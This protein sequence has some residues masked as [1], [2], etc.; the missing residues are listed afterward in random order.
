MKSAVPEIRITPANKK[1]VNNEGGFVLYRMTAFRRVN[2]NYRL[3]WS[4]EWAA[5]PQTALEIMIELNNRYALDGS[6]P[7]SSAFSG[8]WDAMT[9]PGARKGGVWKGQIHE[10]RKHGKEGQGQRLYP[11]IRFSMRDTRRRRVSLNLIGK[12]PKELS[13]KRSLTIYN[14]SGES[15]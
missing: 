5:T 3:Q 11:E 12:F 15:C 8:C 6:D 14:Q 10:F 2:W 7:N 13:G 1:M 9:A 4:V